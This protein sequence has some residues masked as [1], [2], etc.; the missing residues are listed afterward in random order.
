MSPEPA[1][2]AVDR[3][4]LEALRAELAKGFGRIEGQF[5]AYQAAH[6]STHA[7]EQAAFNTHLREATIR[8][9][10]LGHLADLPGRVDRLEDWRTEV[11][12]FGTIL[13]LTLGTS[14]IGVI[15]SL[16]AIMSAAGVK[17]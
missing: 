17:P 1:M 2:N 13:R 12:T 15:V 14:V 10:E 5:T 11:R 6:S 9:V 7:A 8:Q 16:I 3:S 4:E